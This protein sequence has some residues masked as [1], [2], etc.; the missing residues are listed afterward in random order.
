MLY[1]LIPHAPHPSMDPFKQPFEPLVHGVVGSIH[2]PFKVKPSKEQST[3]T[4]SPSIPTVFAEVNA[5]QTTQTPDNKNKGKGK[6]KN[7]GNQ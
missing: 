1:D 3:S 7:L 6:G 2:P 5:I 4:I